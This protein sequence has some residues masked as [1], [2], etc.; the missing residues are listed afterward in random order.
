LRADKVDGFA[1]DRLE[2]GLDDMA[3]T[4]GVGGNVF[5]VFLALLGVVENGGDAI[6]C[7]LD[8]RLDLGEG[9]DGRRERGGAKNV[10]GMIV[11]EV[12]PSDG[13][14]ELFGIGHDLARVRQQVLGVDDE[15]LR[16]QLDDVGVDPP[17]VVRGSVGVD[18]DALAL[19]QGQFAEHRFSS[20][21]RIDD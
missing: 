2:A 15:E 13:F 16:G 9:V 19:S 11:R 1:V 3:G 18:G 21:S 4:L 17:A 6:A 12:E 14:G 8:L 20:L 10:V 5:A 7:C